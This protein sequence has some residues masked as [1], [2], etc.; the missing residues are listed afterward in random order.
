MRT[1]LLLL[2]YSS[3]LI[4]ADQPDIILVTLDTTRADHLSLYGYDQPTSPRLVEFAKTAVTVTYAYSPV[5]L[6]LPAHVS[7]LTGMAPEEHGVFLNGLKIPEAL[8]L[9]QEQ[10]ASRGYAT[11]AVVSSAVLQRSSGLNRGF[12]V[13][14]D[15][16]TSIGT[17]SVPNEC[18]AKETTERALSL[19]KSLKS[20][21]FLWVHYFDPHFPYRPPAPFR[22]A[23]ANPYD[24]EIAAMDDSLGKL[25]A[26]IPAAAR[27]VICGDHGEML[28]ERGER[29]HG[30]LLYEPA[31]RVPLLIRAGK[32]E[33]RGEIE[34]PVSLLSLYSMILSGDDFPR[35]SR[36]EES[37]VFT[38]Y[39]G[40]MVYGFEPVRGILDFPYKLLWTG[41]K[42]LALYEVQSDPKETVDLAPRMRR[43]VRNMLQILKDRTKKSAQVSGQDPEASKLLH[44]LGYLSPS[45][46]SVSTLIPPEE[47]LKANRIVEEAEEALQYGDSRRARDLL[48]GVLTQN[49]VHSDALHH[50]ARLS[51]SSGNYRSA[52]TYA[53][54]IVQSQPYRASGY[55][56]RGLAFESLG[57]LK[58]ALEDYA[59]GLRLDD[60]DPGALG[61]LARVNLKLGNL[62]DV[63][64]LQDRTDLSGKPV[65]EVLKSVSR[66]LELRGELPG[67]FRM[68]HSAYTM[69]SGDPSLLPDLARLAEGAGYAGQAYVYWT[70]ILRSSPRDPAALFS[71]AR[72]GLGLQKD[73]PENR[74]RLNLARSL[75][76]NSDLCRTIEEWMS[77]EEK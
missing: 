77:R 10:L 35:V 43:K 42:T 22:A 4:G 58:E 24:G 2:L 52:R 32:G 34:G 36:N 20:P 27:I 69:T 56:L 37:P 1:I 26:A 3:L 66:V 28:G 60:R 73:I 33:K 23:F 39:Y 6:T 19:L 17:G 48:N 14:E 50:M 40:E 62:D 75:C 70:M 29:E 49:P 74:R 68:L 41:A 11:A 53:D 8:P 76:G 9:L 51:L 44:S 65:P 55:I 13:Y 67:A 61:G 54:R 64:A 5:P 71:A 63:L 47:G 59:E 46:D 21:F 72:L 45:R 30:V 31:V 38:T 57:K 16:M 25:I 15:T 18:S 12:D 7:I